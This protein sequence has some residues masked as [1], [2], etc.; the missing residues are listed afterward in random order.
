MLLVAL[1]R[2]EFGQDIRLEKMAGDE[3]DVMPIDSEG[4]AIVAG[5]GAPPHGQ[6]ISESGMRGVDSTPE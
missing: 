3:E 6:R 4:F 1:E 2:F 5:D